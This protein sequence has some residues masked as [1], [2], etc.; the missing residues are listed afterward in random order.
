MKIFPKTSERFDGLNELISYVEKYKG[1]ELQYFDKDGI[2][3]YIDI[4]T[5][6]EKLLEK[7]PYI[8]EI[9]I[10]PPLLYYDIENILFKDEN[11]IISQLKTLVELSQKYNIKFNLVYHTHWDFKKHKE[12]TINKIKS[13][14]DIINGEKV[15]LLLE[16]LYMFDEDECTV[17]K[18]A[19]YINHPNLK[20]CFDICHMYCKA[21]IAKT[22]IEKYIAKYLNKELCKKYIYQVHFSYTVGND[23]YVEKRTHGRVHPSKEDLI[24]DLKLLKEYNMFDCNYITE[25]SEEDYFLR[26]DQ[27]KELKM[28]EEAVI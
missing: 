6:V 3:N 25:I 10:H 22:N 13:L 5:P 28:L 23:G 12:L 1:I 14:L 26:P 11:I 4:K 2:M 8:E 16:N 20:V 17:F 18:I 15:T 7:A 21:N 9:T 19:E 24:Y 27:L